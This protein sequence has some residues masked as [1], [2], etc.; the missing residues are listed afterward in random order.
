[1][2]MQLLTSSSDWAQES[3]RTPI[4]YCA[5][6]RRK[7]ENHGT[8]RWGQVRVRYPVLVT[9]RLFV[10]EHDHGPGVFLSSSQLLLSR[11]VAQ[12]QSGN[13]CLLSHVCS[14]LW[15]RDVP[16]ADRLDRVGRRWV[17]RYTVGGHAHDCIWLRALI[18]L[19]GRQLDKR[20]CSNPD[21]RH[22][23]DMCKQTVEKANTQTAEFQSG[24]RGCR[25][26]WAYTQLLNSRSHRW[27][28][29]ENV[30][31]RLLTL[32]EPLSVAFARHDVLLLIAFHT[33]FIVEFYSMLRPCRKV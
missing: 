17:R 16:A 28:T 32:W 30:L 25:G 12:A 33:T 18:D 1:M 27:S 2:A 23:M 20:K 10:Q 6:R 19:F 15:K 24:A 26:P 22:I 9:Q 5:V 14:E 21:A 4:Y 29:I 3:R 11:C 7:G 31:C 13:A 8:Y